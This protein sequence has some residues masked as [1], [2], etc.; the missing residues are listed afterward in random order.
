[1]IIFT[2]KAKGEK[3]ELEFLDDL[4]FYDFNST[5]SVVQEM[6]SAHRTAYFLLP[7]LE[8]LVPGDEEAP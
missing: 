3:A 4:S 5:I 2:I 6:Q 7:S 1:M 8:P